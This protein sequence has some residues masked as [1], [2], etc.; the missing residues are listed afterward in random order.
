VTAS[1]L[2]RAQTGDSDAFQDLVEPFRR[3]L[4][5]HCYRILG[6]FHDA[7][8]VLQE[9]LLSAWRAIDRFD[10]R[11]TRTW[12]YRIATNRS[13]NF[14]RDAGRRPQTSGLSGSFPV[15]AAPPPTDPSWLEPIPDIFVDDEAVGPEARYEARE[16]IGL[17]FVASL[18]NL[19]AQQRAVL[20]LRD[21]LGFS[22]A[23]AA[24]VLDS[25]PASVNSA[26]Q[27]A[28]AGFR[29][30]R[31][32]DRVAL[33]RSPEEA[34]TVARFVDAFE[35]GDIDA[36]VGLLTHD[37]RVTMPPEPLELNGPAAIGGFFRSRDFW[38][39]GPRLLPTRANKQPAFGYYLPDEND[40]VHRAGGL[41]VLRVR[42][43]GIAGITRFDDQG[44]FDLFGLP[45]SIL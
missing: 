42:V 27:R 20:V 10:G 43:G 25:T 17:S 29:P 7:E 9:T 3:E 6:S 1:T 31:D 35:S 33:P 36:L 44:L 34:A 5:A 26:L 14:L 32:P 15:T 24:E 2:T 13:L 8:D 12:L 4:H 38:G 41:L 45:R 37:A 23:G 19:P 30:T 28:R 40:E 22:A 21:V 39:R 16:S 11:S 18:Q